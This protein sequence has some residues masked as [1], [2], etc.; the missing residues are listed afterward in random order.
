MT[1]IEKVMTGSDKNA[2]NRDSSSNGMC[3]YHQVIMMSHF[4][5]VIWLSFAA[6]FGRDPPIKRGRQEASDLALMLILCLHLKFK[7]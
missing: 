6:S 7:I 2:S 4:P 3:K 1:K 5:K